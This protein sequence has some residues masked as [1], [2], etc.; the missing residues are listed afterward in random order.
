MFVKLCLRLRLSYDAAIDSSSSLEWEITFSYEDERYRPQPETQRRKGI[1]KKMLCVCVCSF[2]DIWYFSAETPSGTLCTYP[3]SW[4]V[5]ETTAMHHVHQ[6]Q[7]KIPLIWSWCIWRIAVVSCRGEWKSDPSQPHS[8]PLGSDEQILMSGCTPAPFI[9][10]YPGDWHMQIPL[11][12]S[13]W[14]FLKVS[15]VFGAPKCN[16]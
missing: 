9:P 4:E 3:C 12:I 5:S 13:Y 15:E 16:P 2:R 11:A 7:M 14:P 10:V 8:Q 1:F 6:L